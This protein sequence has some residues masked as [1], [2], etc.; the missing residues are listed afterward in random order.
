MESGSAACSFKSE[1]WVLKEKYG[2]CFTYRT[3]VSGA[4]QA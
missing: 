4:K 1:R 3:K 2:A